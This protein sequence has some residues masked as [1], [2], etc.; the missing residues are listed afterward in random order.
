M[1]YECPVCG[2]KFNSMVELSKHLEQH[3]EKIYKCPFCGK[4]YN[5]LEE[6][7]NCLKRHIEAEN[8]K[9]KERENER[10]AIAADYKKLCDNIDVL[11]NAFNKVH[12]DNCT[13]KIDINATTSD[14][15][16]GQEIINIGQNNRTKVENKESNSN[17]EDTIS[18]ENFLKAI[19]N[20]VYSFED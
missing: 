7:N 9:I 18:F 1:R 11:I 20:E 19:L 2:V 15:A 8:R 5:S 4:A 12:R 10:K 13:L 6:M 16:L 3:G 14:R 17:K